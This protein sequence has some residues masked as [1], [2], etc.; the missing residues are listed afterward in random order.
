MSADDLKLIRS[1]LQNIEKE[2]LADNATEHTHRSALKAL[3][4]QKMP[5][6]VA[7]NEPRRIECGAP[8]F[9]IGTGLATIGYIVQNGS[10]RK[11]TDG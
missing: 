11:K 2:L 6:V 5:G 9:V 1:Y 7:T 10:I 4:E 3:V 8:D